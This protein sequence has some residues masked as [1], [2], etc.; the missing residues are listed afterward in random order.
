MK[1][2]SLLLLLL[3]ARS[4]NSAENEPLDLELDSSTIY[5]NDSKGFSWIF[6]KN[7]QFSD[8]IHANEC[9][10][11]ADQ[12]RDLQYY[13]GKHSRNFALEERFEAECTK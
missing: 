5:R 2:R 9:Q 7:Y 3:L 8:Q 4:V 12:I 1:H 11:L 10:R 13:R 6:G